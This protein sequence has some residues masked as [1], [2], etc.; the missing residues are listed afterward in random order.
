MWVNDDNFSSLTEANEL[1]K[2]DKVCSV[3]CHGH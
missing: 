1:E 2:I 3:S